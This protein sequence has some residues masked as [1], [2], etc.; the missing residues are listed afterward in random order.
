MVSGSLCSLQ[1]GQHLAR[2]LGRCSSTTSCSRKC[3]GLAGSCAWRHSAW[4]CPPTPQ[5]ATTQ[6]CTGG[7][8][9]PLH[10][11]VAS[12]LYIAGVELLQSVREPV[13][14]RIAPGRNRSAAGPATCQCLRLCWDGK[15]SIY[16][17]G[18]EHH[19]SSGRETIGTGGPTSGITSAGAGR[20]QGRGARREAKGACKCPQR[21]LQHLPCA[22]FSSGGRPGALGQVGWA[23]RASA[24][25]GLPCEQRLRPWP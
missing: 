24:Q 23:W 10:C 20:W 11:L 4:R 2:V 8:T 12:S 21:R 17:D 18:I 7:C 25:L 22:R 9:R 19:A 1:S 16:A 5:R 15:G 6:P 13:A 14:S 3:T